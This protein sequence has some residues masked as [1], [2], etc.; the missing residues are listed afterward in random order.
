MQ[1]KE[2]GCSMSREMTCATGKPI[3]TMCKKKVKEEHVYF[4]CACT[5]ACQ[6]CAE[7]AGMVVEES[8]V[9][10]VPSKS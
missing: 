2:K 10:T 6:K 1:C 4:Y 9:T 3:C 8:K 7:A 5:L